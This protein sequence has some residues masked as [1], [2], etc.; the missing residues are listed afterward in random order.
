MNADILSLMSTEHI[1]SLLKVLQ[2]EIDR[3]ILVLKEI[4]DGTN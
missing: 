2:D 4:N 3:R 1:Q